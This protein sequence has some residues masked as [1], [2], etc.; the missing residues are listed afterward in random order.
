VGQTLDA[1]PSGLCPP[2]PSEL[3]GSQRMTDLLQSLRKTY[4]VVLI[5]TS[6][7]LPVTDAAVLA[8]RV[9]AVLVVARE[10]RTHLQDARAA[11][12]ALD[13]A[14]G[15][16]LGSVLTMARQTGPR[17]PASLTPEMRRR[18]PGGRTSESAAPPAAAAGPPA[19]A[20]ASPAPPQVQQEAAPAPTAQEPFRPSPHPRTNGDGKRER[21]GADET[22]DR[23]SAAR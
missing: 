5:D 15:R 6:P 11:R 1:L 7:V 16:M 12:D 14:S 18:W 10:G 22:L 2:N 23:G 8:L 3:L 21:A 17:R 20:E 13:V 9:D 4:D 19:P